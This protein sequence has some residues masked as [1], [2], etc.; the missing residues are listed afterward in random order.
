MTGTDTLL[1][2]HRVCTRRR[3]LTGWY[4]PP[5]EG[6]R[7]K[8]D[9]VVSSYLH[10][11]IPL[12]WRG[13][14]RSL[15]G[16]YSPPPGGVA[17]EARRGGVLVSAP[18]NSPPVEGWQAQPDGVVFSYPTNLRKLVGVD[19]YIRPQCIVLAYNIVCHLIHGNDHYVARGG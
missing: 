7:A 17:G 6:W 11:A 1:Q 15:T 19:L 2:S 14:R 8:P 3:S 16:W 18:G 10:P 5:L 9:G 13:G 4:S 12:L